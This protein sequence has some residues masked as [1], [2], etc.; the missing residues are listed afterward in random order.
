[1]DPIASKIFIYCVIVLSAV[2]HEYSHGFIANELGDPTAKNAGRLTLNPLAHLDPVGTVLV[3]L[4]LLFTSGA[5]IGWA[6]PVPYNPWNIRDPKGELKI[7]IAGPISNFVLAIGISLIFW[8]LG[9]LIPGISEGILPLLVAQIIYV[10]IVLALFNLIP[11]PPLDGSKV[12]GHILPSKFQNVLSSAGI[13]G[14]LIALF[15]AMLIIPPVA[16]LV[17]N[18]ITG[19]GAVFG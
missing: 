4:F 17:F 18:L 3:P 1:M 14:I 16:S 5:F 11:I 6:K 8:I 15:I 19:F 9:M 2:V 7:A 12:L 13:F 10:N